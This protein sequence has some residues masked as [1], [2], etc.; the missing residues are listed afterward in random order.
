MKLDQE[1]I[2]SLIIHK[3]ELTL[4]CFHSIHG[5]QASKGSTAQY[6]T[7]SITVFTRAFSRLLC[8]NIDHV[9][10]CLMLMTKLRQLCVTWYTAMKAFYSYATRPTTVTRDCVYPGSR[11]TNN[12]WE[13]LYCNLAYVFNWSRTKITE[14]NRCACRG[15][16]LVFHLQ[17]NRQ[18]KDFKHISCRDTLITN[19]TW[20]QR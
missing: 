10:C 2:K 5:M 4:K 20:I 11:Q 9:R 14:W 17:T 13:A 16:L 1:S 18:I 7:R 6:V 8:L 3:N 19:K 12:D 15:V